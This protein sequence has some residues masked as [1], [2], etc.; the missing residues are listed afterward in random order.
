MLDA[1]VAAARRDAER[2]FA[3]SDLPS[4]PWLNNAIFSSCDGKALEQSLSRVTLG[5]S[6]PA[7]QAVIDASRHIATG[8]M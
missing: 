5:N 2:C 8:I 7:M 4:L 3:L 1:F 6:T